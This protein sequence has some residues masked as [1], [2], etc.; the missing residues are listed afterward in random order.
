MPGDGWSQVGF[1]DEDGDIFDRMGEGNETNGYFNPCATNRLNWLPG[2]KVV[3]PAADGI[4]RIY[5]FDHPA[6]LANPLL[7]LRVPSG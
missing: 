7:A 3:Q 1:R 6:A 4:W 5:R 2:S